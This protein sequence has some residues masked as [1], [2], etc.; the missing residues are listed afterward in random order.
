MSEVLY[1][2][3]ERELLFIRQLA[4]EFAKQ[5]PVAAGRLYLEPNRS[6][7]PHIERLIESF[8]LLS[9]RIHHKLDD[10]FP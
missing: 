10:D 5:Y 7:D 1:P 3:Y 2:Y 8:A 9:G 6:A 4:Q